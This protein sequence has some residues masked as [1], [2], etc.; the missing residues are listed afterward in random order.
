MTASST[1]CSRRFLPD[2]PWARAGA[3]LLAG[4]FLW[5]CLGLGLQAQAAGAA[6]ITEMRLERADEGLLLS[7]SL[8]F[9][10]PPLAEDA[11]QK[12]IPLYFITEAEVLRDRW[13]WYDQQVA[14]AV[15]YLRL[16]FQPLTRRWRLTVS[17][18]PFE[19]S[20]LGVVL[21]QN[22]DHLSDVLAAM[23]RI[24]RW[25]IAEPDAIDPQARYNA[26]LRFRLDLSQLPRPLQIGAMGR[27]GWNLSMARSQ[28]LAVE[29]GR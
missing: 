22:F 4:L 28:R 13:Y 17:S 15:R 12:G 18:T 2:A 6:D 10:L 16:S 8:Q 9:D 3:R 1:R 24:V 7:A 14:T 29:P 11:L 25:K 20:G 27:S 23:Q 5:V 21:G 26:Q 19:G